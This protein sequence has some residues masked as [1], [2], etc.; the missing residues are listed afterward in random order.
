MWV[1]ASAASTL[2]VVAFASGNAEVPHRAALWVAVVAVAAFTAGAFFCLFEGLRRL[3]AV[4]TAIVSAAE[5]LVAAVLS[6]LV[7]GERLYAGTIVGGLMI[8]GGAVAASVAR[9]EVQPGS[10]A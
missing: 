10:G 5:P 4:R 8:L 2:A 7:F 9:A 3:G 6:V 1:S